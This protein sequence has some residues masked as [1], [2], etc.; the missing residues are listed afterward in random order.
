MQSA[1]LVSDLHGDYLKYKKL[2]DYIRINTP[3]VVFI[4]G[5]IL[6]SGIMKFT[7]H[8]LKHKDFINGF[9]LRRFRDLKDDLG[10]NYPKVYL[11][12]GNDDARIE[13]A[14]L[15]DASI[16]TVWEYVNLHRRTFLNYKVFGYCYVPPS[17]FQLKDWEKYDVSRYVDP[18]CVSPEEGLRTM[19][20]R[21]LAIRHETIKEDL[22]DL[23]R[24]QELDNAIILFHSPPYQTN[25][26]RGDLDGK[27]IDHVPLDVHLGSIAIKRFIEDRQPYI[28]LHGHIHESTRLTGKWYDKIGRTYCFNA[29]HDGPELSIV[30]FD[31]VDP[32]DSERILI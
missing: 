16:N 27:K 6:P 25:L 12:L 18:G 2:I 24:D 14:A 4:A 1:F 8:D 23:V 9:L 31:L 15:V 11:I 5:D 13:E 22:E 17:P 7:S 26:D 28:T 30:I 32:S 20:V 29:A 3:K 10:D 21:K 19:P